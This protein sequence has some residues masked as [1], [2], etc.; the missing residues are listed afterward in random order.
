MFRFIE[1]EKANHS[2][3]MMCRVL[4]VSRSGY[5]KWLRWEPSARETSDAKLKKVIA[6]I[7]RD[8]RGTYGSPRVHAELRMGK[9]IRCSRKRVIRLMRELGIHGARRRGRF[10]CTRRD[11]KREA[12]PDL[13]ERR[14]CAGGPNRLWVADMTQHMTAQGRL[15][16][17][18]VIDVFSRMV[19]G[20]SMGERQ[21][22][23][24]VL[25]ALN[26]AVRNRQSVSGVTHHSD[27]GSQYTSLQFGKRLKETGILGSMGSVGDALDNAVAESFFSTLQTELLDRKAWQSRAQLRT[28]IFE[29]TEVFYNRKRRHSSLEYMTPM[30][31]ERKSEQQRLAASA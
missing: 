31:F 5:Y 19:V 20:W 30:E 24:L 7:H 9:N 23:D 27:H 17:A 18:V 8:S 21:T 6:K 3:K 1:R 11:P 29:Y 25:G 16:L 4:K 10:G 28:A 22:V 12:Y 15:Y 13:V 14:F 26:M 2:V